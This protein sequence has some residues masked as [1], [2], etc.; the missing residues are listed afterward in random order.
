M[1]SSGS[2]GLVVGAGSLL[3]AGFLAN[4]ALHKGLYGTAIVAATGALLGAVAILSAARRPRPP[5]PADPAGTELGSLHAERRRLATLLDQSPTPLLTYDGQASLQAV[6]RAARRLFRTDDFVVPA[7]A[8][9]VEAISGA[10]VGVAHRVE[11]NSGP[12]GEERAFALSVT[13]IVKDSTPTRLIALTDIES[14]IQVASAAAL[15]ELLEV[16]SHELMNAVAPIASLAGTAADYLEDETPEA[17]ACARDALATL[18]RRTQGVVAFTDAYRDLMKLPAPDLAD[19]SL[20]S[21][22]GDLRI[23]FETSWRG[24]GVRL[25]VTIPEADIF[26]RMDTDQIVQAVWALLQ[27]AAEA[28]LG[29]PPED[30]EVALSVTHNGSQLCICVE[31]NGPGF[32]DVNA[33]DAFRPFFTTKASGSGVGLSLARQIFK[34]HGGD[35]RLGAGEMGGARLVASL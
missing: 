2:G 29:N 22:V 11:L 33:E 35:L 27:N 28:T 10:K 6:N 23:L 18:V 24:E 5:A 4:H 3:A 9:L 30:R 26:V 14:E 21:T 25:K 17:R 15:R 20:R 7:P 34:A 19:A 32:G 13:E 8:G 12:E 16:L 1:A 31:D